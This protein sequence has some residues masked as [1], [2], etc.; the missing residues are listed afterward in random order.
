MAPGGLLWAD[1][2]RDYSFSMA[3]SCVIKSSVA[4]LLGL[5]IADRMAEVRNCRS[6]ADQSNRRSGN[7]WRIVMGDDL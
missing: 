6:P 1:G 4:S 3:S 2:G 7:R 5:P